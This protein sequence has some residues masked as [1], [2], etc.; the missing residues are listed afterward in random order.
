[1]TVGY[2]G[3]QMHYS[4]ANHMNVLTLKFGTIHKN[5]YSSNLLNITHYATL[6]FP[7]SPSS[8]Q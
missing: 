3:A 6:S 1:M 5:I 4:K 8:F 7:R 2:G